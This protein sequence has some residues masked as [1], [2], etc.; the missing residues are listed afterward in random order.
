MVLTAGVIARL[1]NTSGSV[2]IRGLS[3]VQIIDHKVLN[4]PDASNG[5]RST[6]HSLVISD[7]QHF[8]QAMLAAQHNEQ[9]D[10]G[11]IRLYSVFQ[12]VECV[13]NVVQNKK[14]CILLNVN[15]MAEHP[16]QKLGNP[17]AFGSEEVV[18]SPEVSIALAEKQ[19]ALRRLAAV[20]VTRE[21]LP[22]VDRVPSTTLERPSPGLL[23]WLPF[24]NWFARLLD[25]RFLRRVAHVLEADSLYPR[26]TSAI[27]SIAAHAHMAL[28]T[29]Q[30][31]AAAA[32]PHTP[33]ALLNGDLLC[34]LAESA[35]P[36]SMLPLALSCLAMRDAVYITL[37]RQDA[38]LIT[39]I[40]SAVAAGRNYLSW[41]VQHAGCPLKPV[42]RFAAA[43]GNIECIDW[44]ISYGK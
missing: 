36:D 26:A 1:N 15:A 29:T 9:V 13:V 6:S 3:V 39:S 14:I 19:M 37:A 33:L 43:A 40:P 31:A 22:D 38:N 21:V 7:G 28:S 5:Q 4:L 30:G 25:P 11:I 8:M 42:A 16:G 24:A 18:V 2:D 34:V 17:I 20:T 10:S 41:A 32:P 23:S 35:G 44:A 12:L 27:V